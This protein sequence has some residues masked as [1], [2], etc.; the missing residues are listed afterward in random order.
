MKSS[1]AC[2]AGLSVCGPG[3]ALP[4]G[5]GRLRYL[6]P[7]RPSRP[8][9]SGRSPGPC[10]CRTGCL[11]PEKE[12]GPELGRFVCSRSRPQSGVGPSDREQGR[13]QL[14]E[15]RVHHTSR[16]PVANRA[17]EWCRNIVRGSAN[18]GAAFDARRPKMSCSESRVGYMHSKTEKGKDLIHYASFRYDG[19]NYLAFGVVKDYL[20]VFVETI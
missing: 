18:D 6:R 10:R 3:P 19:E 20:P 11:L 17:D 2:R 7:T 12:D 1:T 8:W 4:R 15:R 13:P 9:A 14:R 5:T 16:R